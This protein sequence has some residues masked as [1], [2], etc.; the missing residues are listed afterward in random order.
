MLHVSPSGGLHRQSVS[1]GRTCPTQLA[2]VAP[3]VAADLSDRI[4][5][6]SHARTA[7]AGWSWSER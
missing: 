5:N 1:T 6:V 2:A 7:R 4:S 3:T